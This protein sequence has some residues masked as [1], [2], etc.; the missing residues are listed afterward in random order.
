MKKWMRR[1]AIGSAALWAAVAM[2]SL[3]SVYLARATPEWYSPGRTGEDLAGQTV[4]TAADLFSYAS[5]VGAAQRRNFLAGR[6]D[7]ISVAATI[8][9]KTITIGEDQLNAFASQWEASLGG[10]LGGSVGRHL[11]GGRAVLLEGR[12][13]IAGRLVDMGVLSDTVA[14]IEIEP[15]LDDHGDIRPRLTHVYSGRLPVPLALLDRPRQRL[16]DAVEEALPEW[17]VGAGVGADGLGNGDAAAV[18]AAKL[19]LA[20]LMDQSASGIFLVPCAVGDLRQ[21][22]PLRITNLSLSDWRITATVAPL[23]NAQLKTLLRDLSEGVAP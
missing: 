3:Y 13:I 9:P 5:D 14:S 1:L 18:A 22:V 12:L 8:P 10:R 20:A 2:T 19:I 7:A 16:I 21:T 23:A 17:E 15:T 6:A 4:Q 11:T